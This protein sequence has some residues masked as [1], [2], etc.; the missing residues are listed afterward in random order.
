MLLLPFFAVGTAAVP[1]VVEAAVPVAAT[2]SLSC[3]PPGI[4]HGAKVVALSAYQS[5]E[6]RTMPFMLAGSNNYTVHVLTVTGKEK[7]P[8]VLVVSAYEPILW[9][10][11]QVSDRVR[12]VV[13]SGYY[14]QAVKGLEPDVPVRFSSSIG[15]FNGAETCAHVG[16]AYKGTDDIQKVATDIKR[17]IGVYP[18]IFYGAYSTSQLDVDGPGKGAAG[19]DFSDIRTAVP[20]ITADDPS[21]KAQMKYLPSA[22]DTSNDDRR[23]R[24]VEWNDVGEVVRDEGEQKPPPSTTRRSSASTGS[25]GSSGPSEARGS[26]GTI[27]LRW[28]MLLALG[29]FAVWKLRRS[30]RSSTPQ[31][32]DPTASSLVANRL[33]AHLPP[34]PVPETTSALEKQLADLLVLA[35]ITDCEPL[36]VSL[37]RYGREIK[38]VSRT[39]F[40]PD[41]ADESGAIV[42]RHFDH[43]TNRYKRVRTSL[44]G[45]E[46]AQADGMLTRAIER[47][48]VRLQELQAEQHRRDVDGVDEAARFINARHPS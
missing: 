26:S 10:L 42:E 16:Y 15:K 48:A 23:L 8:I 47:L 38:N 4:T 36:V 30:K 21:S 44:N 1:S 25:A 6:G 31:S 19:D 40:D 41:L 39:K 28:L 12:A 43:A 17:A 5:S 29:T 7:G 35:E 45:K 2:S 37:H 11:S 34:P 3:L 33:R 13:A 27:T 20:L 18:R 9:D 46:G 32:Q 14:P 24:T 22:E